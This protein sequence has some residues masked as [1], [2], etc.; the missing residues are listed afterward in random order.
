VTAYSN[1]LFN[2]LER[3]LINLSSLEQMIVIPL[4]LLC[5][6]NRRMSYEL[7]EKK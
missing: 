7:T 5:K 2:R 6:C 4:V 3:N 1:Y